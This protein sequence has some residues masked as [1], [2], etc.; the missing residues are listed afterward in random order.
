MPA[1]AVTFVGIG[2]LLKTVAAERVQRL[3]LNLLNG[4]RKIGNQMMRFGVETDNRG[5]GKKRGDGLVRALRAE[6]LVVNARHEVMLEAADGFRRAR[7]GLPDAVGI[8]FHQRAVPFLNF[9]NAVLDGHAATIPERRRLTMPYA[10]S[11]KK[12]FSVPQ[13][14]PPDGDRNGGEHKQTANQ[15]D[16]EVR[17]FEGEPERDQRGHRQPNQPRR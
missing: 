3:V 7:D 2:G 5:V 16:H 12:G 11:R 10:R 6:N 9:D 4:R 15:L 8:E 17:D 13:K 14:K 1:P